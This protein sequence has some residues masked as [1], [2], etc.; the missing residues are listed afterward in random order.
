MFPMR[1]NLFKFTA[2][3]S[4][5]KKRFPVQSENF[6]EWNSALKVDFHSVEFS[7]WTGNP[8]LMCENVA[9]NLNKML[10]V[11]KILLSKIQS[12]RKILLSGNHP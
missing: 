3:F 8:L 5:I 1:N 10:R 11:T 9:V 12:A 4:H 2:T 6:T 7:D